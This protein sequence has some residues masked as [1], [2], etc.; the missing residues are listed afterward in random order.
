MVGGTMCHRKEDQQRQGRAAAHQPSKA[1]RGA[2]DKEGLAV[3]QGHQWRLE[4][5]EEVL[6]T[7][8]QSLSE[9]PGWFWLPFTRPLVPLQHHTEVDKAG[10]LEL[11]P[12]GFLGSVAEVVVGTGVEVHQF[13]LGVGSVTPLST[14]R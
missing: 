14:T 10:L 5:D 1:V 2:P 3:H 6:E 8:L 7:E 12:R 9:K 4:V 11:K 13:L